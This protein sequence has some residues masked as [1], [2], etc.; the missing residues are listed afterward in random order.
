MTKSSRA[1]SARPTSPPVSDYAVVETILSYW[2]AQDV[3]LTLSLVSEDVIHQLYVCGSTQPCRAEIVGREALAWMMYNKLAD[4]DYLRFDPVILE[5]RN[6]V[7]RVHA[8][9]AIRHRATG[10]DLAGSKRFVCTLQGGLIT[11]IHEYQD[12]PMVE[13]FKKLTRSRLAE[14]SQAPMPSKLVKP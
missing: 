12:G 8:R 11:R 6:G 1:R 4:F 7:A 3:E 9:Y 14:L 10:E 5:V 13:A 2:S